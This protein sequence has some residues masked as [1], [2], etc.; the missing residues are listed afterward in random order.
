MGGILTEFTQQLNARGLRGIRENDR[1][2]VCLEGEDYQK[3]AEALAA[4]SEA[5]E[6]AAA[7]AAAG[8][9]ALPGVAQ[10]VGAD[11]AADAS[12]SVQR[13]SGKH[14]PLA[15]TSASLQFAQ[16]A[17]FESTA[18]SSSVGSVQSATSAAPPRGMGGF[19][20]LGMKGNK[21]YRS[22]SGTVSLHTVS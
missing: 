17:S 8:E 11:P 15:P 7:A 20:S 3:R 19:G 2:V 13:S 9:E 1:F 16:N 14:D 4:E 6:A 5:V 22:I 12:S 21:R 10:D 18:S